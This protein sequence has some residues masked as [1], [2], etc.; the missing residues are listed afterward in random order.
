MANINKE[1]KE[2]FDIYID[3]DNYL[4]IKNWGGYET[5][6]D[7][8]YL[9]I[10]ETWETYL[11][12][13]LDN[14]KKIELRIYTGDNYPKS[15]VKNSVA[16]AGTQEDFNNNNL[17][18]SFVFHDWRQV[19]IHNYSDK[20]NSIIEASKKKWTDDRVFWIGN[21][22]TH[23]S[24]PKL[25]D[26][27]K[28]HPDTTL[29]T[30]VMW[31]NNNNLDM[32]KTTPTFVS[33]E[34]HTKYRVLFDARPN[35]YSGRLPF[36]LATKRPVIIQKRTNEQWYFYDGTFKPW[37]HYIP[38]EENLSDLEKTINWTFDNPE[39][40][41]KIGQNGYNYVIKYLTHDKIIEKFN[42]ILSTKITKKNSDQLDSVYAQINKDIGD[43]FFEPNTNIKLE[44]AMKTTFKLNHHIIQIEI[45]NN[46]ATILHYPKAYERR[47]E[48]LFK[49]VQMALKYGSIKDCILYLHVADEYIYQY[50]ELP[51]FIIAKP[52]DKTGIL[53]VDNTFADIEP[54][55][56][57]ATDKAEMVNWEDTIVSIKKKCNKIK[58][59]NKLFFIG[60][61]IGLK[62]TN[63]NM[64]EYFSKFNTNNNNIPY[65]VLINGYMHMSEF[66][67]YKY[68]LN[69]PGMSPWS[70]RFKFL[71]LMNSLIINI[72]LL[73]KYGDK[74]DDKWIN[75]FDS[76][77]VPN[78]DY[79]EIEYLYDEKIDQQDNLTKLEHQ[80][81]DIYKEL[82]KNTKK[83]HAI[84]ENGYKKGQ[85]ITTENIAKV[86]HY[87]ISSYSN[88]IHDAKQLK[89]PDSFYSQVIS[90]VEPFYNKLI[91]DS[92]KILNNITYKLVGSGVQGSVYLLTQNNYNWAV[93]IT[94]IKFGKYEPYR[95]T[96][97]ADMINKINYHGCFLKYYGSYVIN[98]NSYM[99]M[100]TASGSIIDWAS[101]KERSIEEWK[102]FI[103]Q[104]IIGIIKL[105]KINITHND[106]QAKNIL[107]KPKK[108]TIK[109]KIKNQVYYFKTEDY[110]YIADF[111]ISA[112]PSLNINLLSPDK[113]QNKNYDLKKFSKTPNKL[114][115]L[116]IIKKYTYLEI[117]EKLKNLQDPIY[118]KKLEKIKKEIKYW[119]D[120]DQERKN[121]LHN[122]FAYYYAKKYF[123]DSDYIDCANCPKK[124]NPSIELIFGELKKLAKNIDTNLESW[125]ARQ[126]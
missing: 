66:C 41:E 119:F 31:V 124:I 80:L 13:K 84:V 90:K 98:N 93:K 61:N 23:W 18:P 83:Y 50:P 15:S 62:K 123:T 16:M 32:S 25:I 22:A 30:D 116:N 5:R 9:L 109:Y 10:K 59:Q 79:I 17:V 42:N 19:G 112:H 43:F 126:F 102:S 2:C 87:I 104:V 4:L 120:T 111:G 96:V 28:K 26:Y 55:V 20:I 51:F 89:S 108:E 11:K 58:K 72:A 38:C 85:L 21:P 47:G 29:F 125:L 82:E 69:F 49:I 6:N 101:K 81:E 105:Q 64:R 39:E 117:I 7:S 68:L 73:R 1:N 70:F 77:F 95:E 76:L 94:N 86:A 44:L 12:S 46:Q 74:Y 48:G 36:L 14:N 115:S 35:G 24:R 53:I 3:T 52:R 121:F 33:L 57:T 122:E 88:N 37:I 45:K 27:S 78:K 71:F 114:K 54:E 8:M 63:F 107:Y 99:S 92:G 91:G 56:K 113:M 40:A 65:D 75:I 34:D 60:Q 103:F 110:F 118:K 106:L 97:F 67:K 100:E